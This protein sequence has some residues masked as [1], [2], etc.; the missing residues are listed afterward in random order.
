MGLFSRAKKLNNAASSTLPRPIIPPGPT[1]IHNHGTSWPGIIAVCYLCALALL[2]VGWWSLV[3]LFEQMGGTKKEA[4]QLVVSFPVL[5]FAGWLLKWILL[6]FLDTS[7][8]FKLEVERELTRREEV[9]LLAAQTTLDPGRM[10][11]ADYDFARVILAVMMRA[12]DL[13]AEGRDRFRGR[14]RPWS[15]A[16]SLEAAEKIGVKIS[17]DKA[18]RVSFWLTEHGVITDPD[19][20]QITPAY[21][22]LSNVRALLDK[23]FGKPIVVITPAIR[24]NAGYKPIKT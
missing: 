13:L 11:E 3:F 19:T 15:L 18:N 14:Y 16:S 5:F 10:T 22:D 9:R 1:T 2:P 23:E 7:N 4:A 17:Q 12:Y 6:A 21:P 8:S 24:S 20:G